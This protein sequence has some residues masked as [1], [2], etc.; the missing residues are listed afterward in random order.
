MK[1]RTI[2]W[3][4]LRTI[5]HICLTI[6][7]IEPCKILSSQNREITYLKGI[8]H[9]LVFNAFWP[10]SAFFR[11]LFI[12]NLCFSFRHFKFKN[13][14]LAINWN[15]ATSL[16]KVCSHTDLCSILPLS[17]TRLDGK[18]IL[19]NCNFFEIKLYKT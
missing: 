14:K 2:E 5:F 16:A 9:F 7:K 13:L 10:C 3:R 15:P 12:H 18:E 17:L 8:Y 6:P 1:F 11:L 4:N 19:F